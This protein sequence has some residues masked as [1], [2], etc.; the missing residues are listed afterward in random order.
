MVWSFLT[1]ITSFLQSLQGRNKSASEWELKTAEKA[2]QRLQHILRP[3]FLQ[4]MKNEEFSKCL[5]E[6][7]DYVVWTHLSDTQRYLYE[8]YIDDSGKVAAVLCGDT[9]SPLEAIT[10]LKKLC[11]HPDLVSNRKQALNATIRESGKL[12][13]LVNLVENLHNEG[14]KCL[15]FSPS[16]KIL[17]IIQ[18]VLS[19]KLVVARIDGSTNGKLRQSIVDDFNKEGSDKNALLLSTK[20]AGCGLNLTAA[21][22]V[23]IFSP[24]WNPADDSQAVDRCYRI[25]QTKDVDVF[26]FIT[27]GTV[28]GMFH[29]ISCLK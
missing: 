26:R 13:T 29:F 12:D 10:Y 22:R 8:R 9:R 15:I 14:H 18:G 7:K 28:E 4:R 6:K 24:S 16:T 17:D 20:A 1:L 27:A 5:P 3:H 2:N 23:I 19:S 11:D 21:D 25:G